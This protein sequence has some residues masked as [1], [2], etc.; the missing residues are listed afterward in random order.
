MCV[1]LFLIHVK[2]F[3]SA[4]SKVEL[5]NCWSASTFKFNEEAVQDVGT[6]LCLSVSQES[7]TLGLAD[8][9]KAEKLYM[10]VNEETRMFFIYF[11]F[12]S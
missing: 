11:N 10:M 4:G 7:K 5:G 1:Q 2:N 8:C 9:Q 6:G 3:V 12:S